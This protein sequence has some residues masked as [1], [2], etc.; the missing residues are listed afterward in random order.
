MSDM[1]DTHILDTLL[2]SVKLIAKPTQPSTSPEE[3]QSLLLE[4]LP[5][6]PME[7]LSQLIPQLLLPQP[8]PILLP[9]ELQS[10]KMSLSPM[11][12]MLDTLD[13]HMVTT[14][15]SAKLIVMLTLDTETESST[16]QL[17]HLL[18]V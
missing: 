9:R 12:D 1:L 11:S 17:L 5:P 6:T 18:E 8:L 15:E 3:L 2:V 7:P 14:S 4:D 16:S 13:G 10:Y